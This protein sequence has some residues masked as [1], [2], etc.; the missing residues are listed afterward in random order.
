MTSPQSPIAYWSTD[1]S[2]YSYGARA[3]D[4][5]HWR[6]S[7]GKVTDLLITILEFYDCGNS[8]ISIG[9]TT[10]PA[11]TS[12]MLRFPKQEQSAMVV[13]LRLVL[14]AGVLLLA[15]VSDAQP[16]KGRGR[17]P[18]SGKGRGPPPEKGRGPPS[19]NPMRVC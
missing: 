6:K 11:S 14:L 10:I 18:P 7:D 17:G 4:M 19:D 2:G 16:E 3:E 13:S 5:P 12:S 15:A 1:S 8:N 9:R